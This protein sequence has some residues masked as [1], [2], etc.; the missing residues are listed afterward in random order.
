MIPL[1]DLGVV[2]NLPTRE[3][4]AWLESEDLHRTEAGEGVPLICLNSMLRRFQK[5]NTASPAPSTS[6]KEDQ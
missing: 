5:T 3:V 6:R 4:Q 2:S 1:D